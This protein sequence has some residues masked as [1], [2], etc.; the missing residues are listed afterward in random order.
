VAACVRGVVVCFGFA[1]CARSRVQA[2]RQAM[3]FDSYFFPLLFFMS[4]RAIAKD[5]PDLSSLNNVF[6][7]VMM[8]T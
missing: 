3:V 5:L 6:L 8:C 7:S 2:G 4:A 1:L